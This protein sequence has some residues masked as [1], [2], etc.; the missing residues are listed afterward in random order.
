MLQMQ[1]TI[2][3]NNYTQILFNFFIE[4]TR[5]SWFFF[6]IQLTV[7]LPAHQA[8]SQTNEAIVISVGQSFEKAVD[9]KAKITVS[10][11]SVIRIQDF[12][13]KIKMT[14]KKLGTSL[15]RIGNHIVNILVSTES[16]RILF[17]RLNKTIQQ[18]RGLEVKVTNGAIS[19]EGRL[20]RFEDWLLIGTIASDLQA[21]FWF[22]A[23]IPPEIAAR[24][25][26]YFKR[27]FAA[28][29]LPELALDFQTTASVISPAEPAETKNRVEQLLKPYGFRI[30]LSTAALGLEPMV[31]V[32]LVVVELRKDVE[33]KLGIEWPESAAAQLLPV[34]SLPKNLGV[35]I[36]ALESNGLAKIL[37]SPTLLCRSGKD[38]QFLAGGEIPIKILNSRVRDIIW[39][40]YGVLLKIRPKADYSGRMSIGI[41]TEVSMI[42]ESHKVDGIPG[43]HTNRIESHF[44]LN[45]SR[46]IVLS[47]L[48]KK[49]WSETASGLPGLSS[50][51]ILGP[52]FKSQEFKE[53]RSELVVFVTPEL[54]SP[55]Q[56]GT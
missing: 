3:F 18:M 13:P 1:K 30:E 32:R 24:A 10:N 46:T 17:D 55:D 35:T 37:A 8:Q 31:R 15:V 50:L 12:G 45:A 19:V 7:H 39:K 29:N 21:R 56:E 20:L 14:G 41:E 48:I 49:D 22:R 11:G 25:K 9:I 44:D 34:L 43:M 36:Q 6:F 53:R 54:A 27:R 23:E 40:Q 47:G 2:K 42:D 26:T 28:A 33:R 16:D 38:A 4:S 5:F 52:L 51:P